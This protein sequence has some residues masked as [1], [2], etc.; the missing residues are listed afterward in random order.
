MFGLGRPDQFVH[1][2]VELI[3]TSGSFDSDAEKVT[4]DM[5]VAAVGMRWLVRLGMWLMLM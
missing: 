3:L 5:A 4:A 2:V 1:V